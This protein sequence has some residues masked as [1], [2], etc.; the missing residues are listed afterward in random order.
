MARFVSPSLHLRA[1]LGCSTATRLPP[2]VTDPTCALLPVTTQVRE[3]ATRLQ[4]ACTEQYLA[5]LAF[6]A[7][8]GSHSRTPVRCMWM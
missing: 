6:L 8:V 5:C 7:E 3:V 2:P 4:R 1:L